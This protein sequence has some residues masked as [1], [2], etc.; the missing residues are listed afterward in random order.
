MFRRVVIVQA[1]MASR[2]LPGKV[3][4]EVAGRSLLD[5]QLSRL[6]RCRQVDDIWIAT[7]ESPD[8]EPIAAWAQ[9]AGVA[10]FRGAADDVLARYVAAAAA[11]RAEVVVRITADCPLV[12]PQVVD[13]VISELTAHAGDCDYASN[14]LARTFPRGLDV[15]AFWLDVLHR[16]DRLAGT[17]ESREH[18]TVAVRSER[19]EVFLRRNVRDDVDNSDLR[20]TVDTPADLEFLQALH[21]AVDLRDAAWSYRDL[22]RAIRANPQLRALNS[23][24][25]TWDPISLP[26]RAA[27]RGGTAA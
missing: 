22:V 25:Q 2:R 19:P 13:R 7:T 6:R 18:V 23:S 27:Q 21:A 14:V 20:W 4:C 8:D 3:L 9:A 26:A 11:A 12:D 24:C 17:L 5:W 15:E 10:C 1:R 16:L